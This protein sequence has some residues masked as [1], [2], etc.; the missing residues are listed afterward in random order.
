MLL[1]FLYW[2]IMIA[3]YL[4]AS[5]VRAHAEK[6][7]FIEKTMNLVIYLLVC[8]MGLRMGAN[9]EVTSNLGTIGLQ[10]VLITLLTV[11]GSMLAVFA[12]RKLVG[13]D[14]HALPVVRQKSCVT[15]SEKEFIEVSALAE[16]MDAAAENAAPA[17]E[18]YAETYEEEGSE[19][20]DDPQHA[21]GAKTTLIILG[22]V[23]AGMLGGYFLIPR[24]FT[25]LAVFQEMSGTWLTIGI[26][27]LLGLVGFNMG[28]SGTIVQNLKNIGVKVIFFP[29]AA[30]AGSL[31]A[32]ALYG[33]LSPL[34]I[35]EAV[36]VSAGF[37]WYTL[38]PSM[39]TEAG[40]AVAGAISFMHN[41]IRETLGIIIIPLAA[42]KIG[43]LESTAIPGV[44]A[45]DVCMPIVERSCNE[46]T[47]VYS[48]CTGA[49]MCVAVPL[50]VPLAV[51]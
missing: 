51:G 37:G 12:T 42:Q 3:C 17:V 4:I 6:F 46:E 44:A 16:E 28:L 27:I 13:L 10:S 33:I 43:Y 49:L 21:S 31:L 47:I 35:G 22:F 1:L 20:A 48:F 15:A 45:M 5:K 25:D 19:S 23:I 39:I 9:E 26:C 2:A 18:A 40:Y 7:S 11:G 38:A 30:V 14:R 8:I 34:S 24:F 32:G 36:A 41:V 50:V 29:I